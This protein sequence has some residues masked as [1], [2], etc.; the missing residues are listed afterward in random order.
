MNKKKIFAAIA[1]AAALSVNN[2]VYAEQMEKCKIVDKNGV[3]LIKAHKADCKS[4]HGSCAGTN[5][6]GDPEAWIMV[7][8]GECEKI[9]KSDFTGIPQD[10]KDKIE[11]A[12]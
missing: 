12:N 8:V 2:G 7:P 11:G 4:T 10:I 9:K 1:T 6:S 3:G 5:S